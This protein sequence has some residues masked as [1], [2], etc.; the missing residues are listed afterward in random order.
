MAFFLSIKDIL[1]IKLCV[2]NSKLCREMEHELEE[3]SMGIGFRSKE[4][5]ISSL[6]DHRSALFTYV[7]NLLD[8][9]A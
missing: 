3:Q 5:E 9:L 1:N 7:Q 4:D 6:F 2:D 8:E